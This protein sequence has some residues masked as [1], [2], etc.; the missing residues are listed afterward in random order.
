MDI[1]L[2]YCLVASNG[3]N[4]DFKAGRDIVTTGAKIEAKTNG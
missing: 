2:I 4:T 3:K 1:P